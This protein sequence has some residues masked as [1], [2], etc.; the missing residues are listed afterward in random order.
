MRSDE[1]EAEKHQQRAQIGSPQ[2]MQRVPVSI[3]IPIRNEAGNLPRCLESV[4][5]ADEIIVVDSSSAD[6]SQR[7]ACETSLK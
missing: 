3:L 6:G 1:S 4:S 2:E 7:I 5:W